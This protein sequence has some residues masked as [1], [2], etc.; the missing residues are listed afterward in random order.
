M[1]FIQGS[2]VKNSIY[3]SFFLI[4]LLIT[5]PVWTKNLP[6]LRVSLTKPIAPLDPSEA[7]DYNQNRI[8][9]NL[10][11][12]LT[13]LDSDLK[14][15][16]SLA[17]SWVFSSDKKTITFKLKK[18][19]WSNKTPIV[20]QDFLR[21]LK[22]TFSP[23]VNARTA[24]PLIQAVKNGE[25]YKTG[26]LKSFSKVGLKVLDRRTFQV[27]LQQPSPF[28]LSLLALPMAFP[29]KPYNKR[30]PH[31]GKGSPT[32]GPYI[33]KS[34]RGKYRL[35]LIP[36]PYSHLKAKN[37][38]E[39]RYIPELSTATRLFEKKKLDVVER[40]PRDAYGRFNKSP[41]LTSS[42]FLATYGVAFNVNQPPFDQVDLRKAISFSL[43]RENLKKV[44]NPPQK[45]TNQWVPGELTSMTEPFATFSLPK[46]RSHW[47]RVKKKPRFITLH[48][49]SQQKN[50]L[51]G[52]FIQ[53]ALK[54]HL[55]L[56]VKLK[57]YDW[58]TF[59]SKLQENQLGF[60]RMAW[61]AAYPDPLSHLN[62]YTEMDPNNFSSFKNTEYEELVKS[63]KNNPL[64]SERQSLIHKAQNI[65]TKE[66]ATVIPLF[67]YVHYNL[68]SQDWE[69][70][71]ATPM[72][73]FYFSQATPKNYL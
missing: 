68:I 31:L 6:Q 49:D 7:N 26:N 14:P 40:I 73:L 65:L 29:Q 69:N 34:K 46:A 60:F 37:Q 57:T 72:G 51:I 59:V 5:V 19:Q 13:K 11:S 45:I 54:R 67:H 32:S 56:T 62:I 30:S 27:H 25:Q 12:G 55:G 71:K 21:G 42:P 17:E 15:I 22:H 44:I 3:W 35:T 47:K 66:T 64:G 52:Q 43:S 48:M 50:V 33:I 2:V 61:L 36:N 53:H 9:F 4:T 63:I 38:L 18:A 39:F 41:S 23:G 20:A 1:T 24:I 8:L 16:P 58:K 10:G 70:I 28:V